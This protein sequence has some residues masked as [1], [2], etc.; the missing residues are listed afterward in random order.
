MMNNDGVRENL[1]NNFTN[2]TNKTFQNYESF[3][4]IKNKNKKY[5]YVSQFSI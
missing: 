2:I 1:K 3:E 4:L 5:M